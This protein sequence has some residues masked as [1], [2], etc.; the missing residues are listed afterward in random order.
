MQSNITGG[1]TAYIFTKKI[2][3]KYDVKYYKCLQTGYI[4]TE[5]PYWLAEAYAS[6]ITKLDVGL[7]AR[8]QLVSPIAQKLIYTYFNSDGRFLDYAGG[9]GLFTRLMRDKGY[10]FY[11]TDKY[12]QNIFAEF[13]DLALLSDQAEFEM[14]TSFE[15]VEHLA[16]PYPTLDEMFSHSSSIFFT[17]EILPT[18]VNTIDSWWYLS[19]ETGQHVG[20]YTTDA[21]AYMAKQYDKYFYTDGK[22][23][24]LFTNKKI[25]TNPFAY[26]TTK[27]EEPYLIKKIRRMLKRFEQKNN[28][29]F[30]GNKTSLI[31]NDWLDA[32]K[33][34]TKA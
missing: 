15:V 6:A 3:G 11:N 24:H 30:E 32:K 12:C 10:N 18:H 8:N 34:I 26:L 21:L 22:W 20:L 4:Q 25:D 17:T 19:V 27:V 5:E 14:I 7:V 29:I 28:M 31:D 2:L 23:L 16:K 33:R 9:Y 13:H 1:E